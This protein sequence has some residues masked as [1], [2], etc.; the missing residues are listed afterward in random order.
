MKSCRKKYFMD[1]EREASRLAK[2]VNPTEW[3]TTHFLPT[4]DVE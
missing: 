1:D 3:I 4:L 2:K